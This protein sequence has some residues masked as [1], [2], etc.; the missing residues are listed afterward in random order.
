MRIRWTLPAAEA[1]ECIAD[2]IARD[3]PPAAHRVVNTLYDRAEQLADFP[4]RGRVGCL[5]NT[6]E[7][8]IPGLP[9]I[10]IYRVRGET[11]E[12]VS[13]FHGSRRFPPDV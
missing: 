2:S 7:L 13:I 6:R 10:I 9:Y 4:L 11:V 5:E 3:N 1:L 12:I 8:L